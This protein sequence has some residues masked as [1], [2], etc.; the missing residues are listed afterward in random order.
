MVEIATLPIYEPSTRALLIIAAA[1]LV[2]FMYG[3][4]TNDVRSMLTSIFG[5]LIIQG[6]R[7]HE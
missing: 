3:L 5:C 6:M 1:L 4:L 2:V 7:K